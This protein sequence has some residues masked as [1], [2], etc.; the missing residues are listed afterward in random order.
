MH[1]RQRK[2]GLNLG[3]TYLDF[4]RLVVGG[5]HGALWVRETNEDVGIVLAQG[6]CSA[7]QCTT[8]TQM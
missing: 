1:T 8:W 6:S 4:A 5:G 7:R 2:G 3:R